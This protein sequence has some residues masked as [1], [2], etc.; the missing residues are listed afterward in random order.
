[1]KR[2]IL[3]IPLLLCV[4]FTKAQYQQLRTQQLQIGSTTSQKVTSISTDS[5]GASK[6]HSALIT[7]KASKNYTDSAVKGVVVTPPTNNIYTNNGVFPTLGIRQAGDGNGRLD[8]N[9]N[10]LNLMGNTS[11]SMIAPNTFV[12]LENDEILIDVSS[13][14]NQL[15]IKD[16]YTYLGSDDSIK[17]RSLTGKYKIMN[18]LPGSGTKA[19]R[20][21]PVSGDL[22]YADTT[23]GSGA[24]SSIFQTNYRA[25]TGRLNVYNQL[26]LKEPIINAPNTPKGYWNAYKQFATASSDSLNEGST[27]LFHTDARARNALSLTTTGSGNATYN[28]STG[29]FNIPNNSFSLA[30]GLAT[31]ANGNKVDLG[32][33]MKLP[34]TITRDST[35]ATFWIYGT[36]SQTSGLLIQNSQAVLGDVRPSNTQAS[37]RVN[38]NT[39]DVDNGGSNATFGI[40]T[41]GANTASLDV[42]GTVRFRNGGGLNKLWVSDATGVGTW[43]TKSFLE[44]TDIF[45]V[46]PIIWDDGSREI[47]IDTSTANYAVVT[48]FRLDSAKARINTNINTIND[49]KQNTL[50]LTTTGSSGP[51]TLIGSTLNIPQYSGGVP[52]LNTIGSTPNDSGATITGTVLRLQPANATYG[53]VLS[54]TTQSWLGNKTNLDNFTIGKGLYMPDVNVG[55][56][57]ILYRNGAA[58]LHNKGTSQYNFFGGYQTGN[59]SAGFGNVGIGFATFDGSTS[60]Y[61]VGIG[62]E[63]LRSMVGSDGF[64]AIGNTAMKLATGGKD[65]IGI[66]TAALY[67]MQSGFSNIAIGKL[68]M[69]DFENGTGNVTLAA[70]TTFVNGDF[71][72]FIGSDGPVDMQSGSFNTQVGGYSQQLRRT[73][74]YNTSLGYGSLQTDSAGINNTILGSFAGQYFHGNSNVLIG[75]GAG[76]AETAISSKFIVNNSTGSTHLINGD[77]SSGKVGINKTLA[78]TV[79]GGS[80]LQVGGTASIDNIPFVGGTADTVLTRNATSNQ[81]ERKLA[82]GG[83]S[84]LTYTNVPNKYLNDYGNF[85]T[86]NADS[87]TAGTTNQFSKWATSGSDINNTNAGNVG[88][89]TASPATKLEVN[90]TTTTTNLTIGANPQG[91]DLAGSKN[92]F[93]AY[94]NTTSSTAPVSLLLATSNAGSKN[95]RFQAYPASYSSVGIEQA[96]NGALFTVNMPLNIGT[97]T[98]QDLKFWASNTQKMTLASN[99]DLS[100]ANLT[101]NGYVKASGGTGLLSV[102]T[103]IPQAD[104]TNL[105]TDLGNRLQSSNFVYN[106]EFTGS[107]S[108]TYTLANTPITG[109]LVVFKNGLKLPNSEFSLSGTTV[110]L[111]S[112]RLITDIFSNDYIK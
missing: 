54:N 4:L 71:N 76:N 31:T 39:V 48:N 53:G 112:A 108:S 102:S 90:G 82:G 73:G 11:V 41:G 26:N 43:Q 67:K 12:N 45:G 40:N 101:T 66:G 28:N 87:I 104:V 56:D 92:G 10:I 16:R 42:N 69:A 32:G 20:I 70:S 9:P 44:P 100:I 25:D 49:T 27:N 97:Y 52:T 78:N 35:P 68:A 77:F 93:N 59:N 30:N 106:E 105:T 86:L 64:V 72:T 107:T 94:F 111:T 55:G 89:G 83:G 33:S 79:A 62:N 2:K 109:K 47:S 99:G 14:N 63:A 22:T 81:L 6:S 50:T 60:D 34:V 29:V 57:G 88:I 37:L 103:A 3:L 5:T 1:M 15:W 46:S 110:T 51:S 21:N 23:S 13:S 8:L 61:S 85:S 36:G 84:G 7:E 17:L 98:G 18:M 75:Y 38:G 80:T 91:V 19:L 24:D 65:A 95:V 74:N 58:W 96:D